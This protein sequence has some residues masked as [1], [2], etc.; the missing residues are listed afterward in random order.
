MY[1]RPVGDYCCP[2]GVEEGEEE[3]GG[4]GKDESGEGLGEPLLGEGA[5][6]VEDAWRGLLGDGYDGVRDIGRV[7]GRSDGAWK[8][9][10]TEEEALPDLKKLKF[11]ECAA[12]AEVAL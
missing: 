1:R 12:A 5:V 2:E 10:L 7:E 4:E 8:G 9:W 3:R 11:A 6:G